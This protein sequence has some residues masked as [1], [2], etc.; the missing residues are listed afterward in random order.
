M[1]REAR[2]ERR[3]DRSSVNSILPRQGEAAGISL[4]E[5]EADE[6]PVAHPPPP[7]P[8][9]PPPPGGEGSLTGVTRQFAVTRPVRASLPQPTKGPRSACAIA[10][11][12]T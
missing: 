6:T 5:G 8:S 4:T 2:F 9:A 3:T 11:S 10:F 12:T 7:S 1:L